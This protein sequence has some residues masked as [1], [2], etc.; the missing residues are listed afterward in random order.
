MTAAESS[1]SETPLFVVGVS[2]RTGSPAALR[3][4]REAAVRSHSRVRAVLVWR[5]PRAPGGPGGHPPAVHS[6]AT[7][8]PQTEAAERLAALVTA[9]LGED[10]GVE[11]VA[12]RGAAVR[13]LL[14]VAED[15]DLL[16]VDSPRP[17]K[18]A[19]MSEKLVAL[20]LIFTSP[21]PVVVMP[22]PPAAEGAG[23]GLRQVTEWVLSAAGT[24]GRP[25]LP[26]IFPTQPEPIR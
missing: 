19:A 15:A 16:V 12:V 9:A 24:A 1:I 3:W 5:P 13:Q 6:T 14:K 10:H 11:C 21:C 25:G 8:D 20:Q 23:H 22:P 4:A 17:T 7:D 18:L 26:P 2:A